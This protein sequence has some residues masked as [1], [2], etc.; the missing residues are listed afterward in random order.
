MN[1]KIELDKWDDLRFNLKHHSLNIFSL[2]FPFF[3]CILQP[4]TGRSICI[5]IQR[6]L[7]FETEKVR[8]WTNRER[9]KEKKKIVRRKRKSVW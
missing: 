9:K 6:D 1:A 2:F 5:H 8:T 7:V 4:G 3:H